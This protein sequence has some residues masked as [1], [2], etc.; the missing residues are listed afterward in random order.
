LTVGSGRRSR[1][2]PN[3]ALQPTAAAIP[4]LRGIR[5]LQAAAV[6]EL[7]RKPEVGCRIEVTMQMNPYLSFKGECEAAFKF[8]EHCLGGQLGA[9]FRYA[10]T[11]LD[12]KS[13]FINSL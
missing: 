2:K 6:A 4:V 11:P 8:Y 3:G 9:I 13:R 7:H 1:S 12:D 10:G 5:P